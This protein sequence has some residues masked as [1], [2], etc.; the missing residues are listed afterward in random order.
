MGLPNLNAG[1]ND[2]LDLAPSFL[3]DKNGK[4]VFLAHI[5]YKLNKMDNII[6]TMSGISDPRIVPMTRQI[7]ASV[8]QDD[9]RQN[10]LQVLRNNLDKLETDKSIPTSEKRA[11]LVLETCQNALGEVYSY[12]N[13]EFNIS[14]FDTVAPLVSYPAEEPEPESP[15]EETNV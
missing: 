13:D 2:S 11:E 7:V 5:M 1:T 14:M 4:S 3:S 6:S 12:L 9:R 8:L 10:L 15:E